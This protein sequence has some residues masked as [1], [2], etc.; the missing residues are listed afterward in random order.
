[1]GELLLF[2][3]KLREKKI[4]YTLSNPRA[5]AVM[6]EICVPG[7]RW[8][9]EFFADGTV[10]VERFRSNGEISSQESFEE[11]FRKFSD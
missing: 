7:E 5:E 3:T 6:V 8:E 9:A 11:L 4:F 2:L 1:M 10:E